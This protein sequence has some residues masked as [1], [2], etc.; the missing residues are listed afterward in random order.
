MSSFG[1]FAS[2][3]EIG[4]RLTGDA[5]ERSALFYIGFA[6]LYVKTMME[7]T[8]LV[9]PPSIVDAGLLLAS[10]C[11][12]LLHCIQRR[13]E[14]DRPV[15]FMGATV[16]FLIGNYFLTGLTAQ[17]TA[18]LFIMAAS[19]GVNKK[20]FVSIWLKVT[21]FLFV[22]LLTIYAVLYVCGND[23][24][25][26]VIRNDGG[27][28]TV[29]LSFFFN[30][31]N[32]AATVALMLVG[33]MLY[34]NCEKR[35]KFTHYALTLLAA[36]FVLY[37]T[38]SR[39][40]ALLTASLAPLYL[41]YQKTS[42]YD[43][44]AVRGAIAVLPV[45][46]FLATYLLMGPLY[47]S[48][49]ASL[50]TGRVWLWH[51]AMVNLGITVLGRAFVPTTAMS[52]YGDW[53]AAA[54]TLDSFYASG[55]LTMGLAVSALFSW[56][57]F[58]SVRM[59]RGHE[60][61]FLPLIVVILLHGFTEGGVLAVAIAFPIVFLSSAIRPNKARRSSQERQSEDDPVENASVFRRT[62][63]LKQSLAEKTLEGSD[64]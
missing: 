26:F 59:A 25:T 40:S 29:R 28:S 51:T 41:I 15:W 10:A 54:S 9:T 55:L 18:F 37:T 8:A 4:R 44:K 21:A 63:K 16:V 7:E 56:A 47:S 27:G 62:N 60:A 58:R 57:V 14:F 64:E 23:L 32:G 48:E 6:L 49:M 22:I 50:F 3:G 42:F 11:F 20:R 17:M 52:F 53:D 30:H 36:L 35:I 24:A 39:T 43:R 1:A 61:A 46:L 33:A 2:C 31:P 5:H 34:L 12:F 45:I 38:D 19:F 13:R